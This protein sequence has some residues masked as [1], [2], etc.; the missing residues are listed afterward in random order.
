M[1]PI[2]RVWRVRL[3]RT[4][5][6]ETNSGYEF[7][8]VEHTDGVPTGIGEASPLGYSAEEVKQ[9]LYAQSTAA[10]EVVLVYDEREERFIGDEAPIYGS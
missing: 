10:A 9:V 3:V 2:E 7:R 4:V 6:G 8:L 1:R 5:I